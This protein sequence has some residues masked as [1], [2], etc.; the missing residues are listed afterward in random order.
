VQIGYVG[1]SND[2][3]MVPIWMSQLYRSP[4]GTIVPGYF[5]GNQTL[6]NEIGVAKLTSSVGYQNY[7]ALQ[8]SFQKRLSNGLEF[9]A[10]YTWS[11]CLTD[12]IGYYGGYGQAQGDHYYW[13][14]TYNARGDYGPCYYDVPHAVN[15]FITYDVPFGR[16]RAFGKNMNRVVDAIA[17]NW[18]VNAI[19]SFRGGFPITIN[20]SSVDNSG[21]N[22]PNQR[23]NCNAPGH[24][25]G[26]RNSPLGG[27]QWFDPTVYSPESP[28]SFGTCG[29]GT[30]RGPGL[31]TVDVSVSKLF[32][33]T[34]HQNLEVRGEAI[35]FSN[36]PILNGPGDGVL[37]STLGVIQ[38]SQGARNIQIGLKYNF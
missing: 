26:E 5:S 19:F 37:D 25:F 11:K 2:H 6:L 16:G 7:N 27:Y 15:G 18:Q 23:A 9:Q 4:N 14:N 21:T 22:N 33:F 8:V 17:G 28:G 1:Q 24:V 30:V 12:S 36:T 35:N 38:N 31:H 13:Q 32:K 20:N 29:V 10:S 3:L 34:E